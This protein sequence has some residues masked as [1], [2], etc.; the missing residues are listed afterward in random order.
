MRLSQPLIGHLAMLAFSI[1]VSVSFTFGSVVAS[2]IDPGVLTLLRFAVATLVLGSVALLSGTRL[3]G[4]LSHLWRWGVIGGLFAAYFITMFE[5]LRLTTPLATAAVFTL[6][7][8]IAAGFGRALL[9]TKTSLPTLGTLLLGGVGALWVIFKADLSLLLSLSIGPGEQ[10]FFLGVI[11]H[12]AVPA[13]T[14]R[15]A[16]EAAP[17]EAALG[18]SF[19][20]LVIAGGYAIPPA[21]VT[22]FTALRPL[23]WWLVLYLG[24]VTTA[25]T[26]FLI[27]VAIARIAPGKVMAYTYLVPSLVLLQSLVL[28]GQ[29]EPPLIYLGV[30]ATLVALGILVRQ[31]TRAS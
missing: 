7:P 12:A 19:G 10:L 11:A 22:D 6:T 13:M 5:A 17:L 2:D 8:L 25:V 9:G 28:W 26:F 3:Q 24:V 31:D 1:L 20:A 14:R 27:Q 15:L 30:A 23:V 16:P 18:A 29:S 4:G 21:L